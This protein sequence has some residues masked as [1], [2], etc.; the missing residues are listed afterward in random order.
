MVSAVEQTVA[1]FGGIDILVNNA[2]TL[3]IGPIDDIKLA[4]FDRMLAVNVR[5]VFVAT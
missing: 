1:R 5:A 3:V 2:G 4:D